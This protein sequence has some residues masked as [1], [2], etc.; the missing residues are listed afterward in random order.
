MVIGSE[1]FSTAVL[2]L[3]TIPVLT[4]NAGPTPMTKILSLGLPFVVATLPDWIS[5]IL[6]SR[7]SSF[8][9]T[10]CFQKRATRLGNRSSALR[11]MTS[12]SLLSISGELRP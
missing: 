3:F 12:S 5:T 4:G 1:M 7:M 2:E 9:T 10:A 11:Q 6:L 8:A